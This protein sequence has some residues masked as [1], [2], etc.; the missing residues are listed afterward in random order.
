ML[1]A[2]H[3]DNGAQCMQCSGRA[4]GLQRDRAHCTLA[5]PPNAGAILQQ[6]YSQIPGQQQSKG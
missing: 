4:T 6:I 3:P 5:G 2:G 1:D